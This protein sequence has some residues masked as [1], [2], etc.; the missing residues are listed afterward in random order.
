MSSP[1]E[2]IMV[3]HYRVSNLLCFAKPLSAG[4]SSNILD[5]WF[6][7]VSLYFEF[8]ILLKK[9]FSNAA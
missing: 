2:K 9:A 8:N 4:G 7:V 5:F 6:G 3:C 1:S